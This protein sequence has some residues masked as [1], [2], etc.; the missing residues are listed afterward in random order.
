MEPLLLGL[1]FPLRTGSEKRT[2]NTYPVVSCTELSRISA[3][4]LLMLSLRQ[5]GTEQYEQT[6][7]K[8][9]REQS[10]VS[11]FGGILCSTRLDAD[12]HLRSRVIA[13][14][15]GLHCHRDLTARHR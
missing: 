13:S 7:K 5:K 8:T 15:K 12:W 6:N 4:F 11:A 3:T 14:S 2:D 10:E 9:H 1:C